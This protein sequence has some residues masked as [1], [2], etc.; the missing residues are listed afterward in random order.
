MVIVAE[1]LRDRPL[2]VEGLRF[3]EE[4]L[5][6]NKELTG[7]IQQRFQN[8]FAKR[9]ILD[10]LKEIK[11][12]KI[13]KV[14]FPSV[15]GTLIPRP[16]TDPIVL[17]LYNEKLSQFDNAITGINGQMQHRLDN[18]NEIAIKVYKALQK[19]LLDNGFELPVLKTEK[20]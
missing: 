5:A 15:G 19:W 7:F 16:V 18:Y 1:E 14:L 20:K 2:S 13:K 11:D 9:E 17:K 4:L 6:A 12:K 10:K 3:V 8:E